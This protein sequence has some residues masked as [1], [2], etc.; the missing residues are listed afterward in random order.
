MERLKLTDRV[1][2]VTGGAGGIGKAGA[3]AMAA[4]G[5]DIVIGDIDDEAAAR[6]V[7]EVEQLGRSALY[8][9]ADAMSADDQRALVEQAANRFGRIDILVN[10]AGGV[11]PR[12]LDDQTDRNWQNIINL[13]LIS[14]VAATQAAARVMREGKRGG[15]VINVASTEALRAAPGFSIYA[16]CKAAMVNFTKTMALELGP[17]GVR[18]NC[19]APDLVITEGISKLLAAADEREDEQARYVPLGRRAEPREAGDVIAFLASD[20]ASW[21]T[22]ATLPVDGGITAAAGW[23][24]GA[25]SGEWVLARA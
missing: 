24:I 2:V 19:I 20:M 25:Q 18:V 14:M 16:A 21:V 15:A 11:R 12:Y 3:M 17:D 9:K 8:V 4:L 5:A 10:N 13:N 6:T 7:S 1:A 22:G 23:H